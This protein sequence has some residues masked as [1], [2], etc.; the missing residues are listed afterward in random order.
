MP[1]P[2]I[3]PPGFYTKLFKWFCKD[4]YYLEL[5]GDLEEEFFENTEE[6]GSVKAA[7]LYKKEVLKMIRPSV[8]KTT[9]I[10]KTMRQPL[11]L[12]FL[13]IGFRNFKKNFSYALLNI[14]GF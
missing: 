14:I 4:E 10:K 3:A 9:F 1:K 12:H 6:L 5:Q 2:K 7:H 8:L 13:K 11:L